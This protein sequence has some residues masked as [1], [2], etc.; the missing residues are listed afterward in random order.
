MSA[1]P[2][3]VKQ[4]GRKPSPS[5]KSEAINPNSLPTP[6]IKFPMSKVD[7]KHAE[8]GSRKKPKKSGGFR[9]FLLGFAIR[10]AFFYTIFAALWYCPSRPFAFD[11]SV[12]DSRSI[13]R[14]IAQT[15]NQLAPI[16]RPYFHQIQRRIDP[17]TQPTIR[18]V[19]PYVKRAA[20]VSKPYLKFAQKRARIIYRRHIDPARRRA[21]RKGLAYLDPHLRKVEAKYR[22]HV[23]PHVDT[24]TRLIK[25]YQD[26]YRRDVSPYVQQ[27]YEYSKHSS[28]VSYAFY[29]DK[30]HPK[31]V[32]GLERSH[33]HLVNHVVPN[34]R[35]LFQLYVRPLIEKVIQK[36]YEQKEKAFGSKVGVDVPEV[37]K[38]QQR[39]IKAGVHL[40]EAQKVTPKVK[41]SV[42]TPAVLVN[43]AD[44]AE[45][46]AEEE[47]EGEVQTEVEGEEGG[48]ELKIAQLDLELDQEEERVKE[49]LEVWEKGMNEM[50]RREYR[51]AIGRVSESRRNK[52]LD[53]VDSFSN[54]E[55]SLVEEKVATVLTR[56]Q[57][58][59]AKYEG[60][61]KVGGSEVKD[62]VVKQLR[63]L[64]KSREESKSSLDRHLEDLK[65]EERQ[66]IEESL[67]EVESLSKK[68][69]EEYDSEMK[70][71][72]FS[73]T[74]DEWEGWDKGMGKRGKMLKEELV[75]VFSG[76]KEV[77]K[78]EEAERD[79]SSRIDL[80]EVPDLEK[81]VEVIRKGSDKVF[82]EALSE[83]KRYCDSRLRCEGSKVEEVGSV[84]DGLVETANRLTSETLVDLLSLFQVKRGEVYEK[85]SSIVQE[86][87][88]PRSSVGQVV[89]KKGEDVAESEEKEEKTL[90]KEEEEV[91]KASTEPKPEET[92][93]DESEPEQETTTT[94]EAEQAK[95]DQSLNSA[96]EFILRDPK[97]EDVDDKL[98]DESRKT[99]QEES[100][101]EDPTPSSTPDAPP[102]VTQAQAEQ[103]TQVLT[104]TLRAGEQVPKGHDEL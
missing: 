7:S 78:D 58:G 5:V 63:K 85:I 16:V 93:I 80:D 8:L 34:A 91:E 69:L 73:A 76:R 83:V 92:I 9:S 18:A 57:R 11:Y 102:T 13:C 52:I 26:I 10:V 21:I 64:E 37:V 33:H 51:S 12:N 100:N 99:G 94:T 77:M 98:V 75:E 45:K 40:D 79:P 15:H 17:Y 25:P 30:V 43:E 4:A 2:P 72:K 46:L 6:P 41:E 56:L 66:A 29:I 95:Q 55:E 87:Q 61:N 32:Q 67:Q 71:C 47:D 59:F 22:L 39:K 96:Q 70:R 14:N 90:S 19:S 104:Q 24:A 65:E 23:Q 86:T 28:S 97:P 31:V 49:R 60:G 101:R 74:L 89:D 36:I 53:L 44:Q 48:D 20:K 35:R 38:E 1:K 42:S 82:N 68:A 50:I 27:A 84:I 88:P 62:L 3:P 54:L 81:V 103:G